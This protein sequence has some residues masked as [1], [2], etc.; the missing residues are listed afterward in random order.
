MNPLPF[1]CV[2]LTHA[3]WS[4]A[5]QYTHELGDDVLPELRLDL[6]PKENPSQL[7]RDLRGRC[8]VSC[9]RVSEGGQWPDEQE[10]ERVRF[11]RLAYEAHP[12]WLDLE[13]D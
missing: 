10:A 3:D 8:M 9:R 2:T 5:L 13:W 12:Q 11:L 1:Y 6:F 4:S 7:V